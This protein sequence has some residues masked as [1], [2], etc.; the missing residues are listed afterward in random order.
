M[1]LRWQQDGERDGNERQREGQL[2]T[3]V[4]SRHVVY[5]MLISMQELQS[6]LTLRPSSYRGETDKTR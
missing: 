2:L 3:D 5:K 6:L 1:A 4:K